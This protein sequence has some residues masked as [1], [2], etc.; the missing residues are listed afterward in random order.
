MR[1]ASGEESLR[2]RAR[3]HGF[4]HAAETGRVPRP[5]EIAVAL[6]ETQAQVE[7][8]LTQLAAGRALI[9]APSSSNVS[10]RRARSVLEPVRWEPA[11]TQ[12]PAPVTSRSFAASCARV[13]L[14]SA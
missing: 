4:G 13:V 2:D 6:R 3:L 5:P 14:L 10:L 12:K 7:A 8:A 1:G 11:T 9:L